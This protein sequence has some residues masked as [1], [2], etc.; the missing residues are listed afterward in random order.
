MS[1]HVFHPGHD[2]LHG[3]TVIL[4]TTGPRV[5][6]GRFD[7]QDEQGVNLIG[8][9]VFDTS[10]GESTKEEFLARTRKF[11]VKVDHPHLRIPLPTVSRI[12]PLGD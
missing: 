8:V 10:G 3:I 7:S 5:L 12:L 2:Q 11:G 1:G 9:S 4:E 6:V